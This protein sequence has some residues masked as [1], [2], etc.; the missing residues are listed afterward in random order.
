MNTF[1]L[2]YYLPYIRCCASVITIV[3]FNRLKWN[4]FLPELS[5][6]WVKIWEEQMSYT[7]GRV[8]L[9]CRSLIG[10]FRSLPRGLKG[11]GL[12]KVDY[13]EDRG[14]DGAC[15]LAS[16]SGRHSDGLAVDTLQHPPPPPLS[17]RSP[18]AVVHLPRPT[19]CWQVRMQ[20]QRCSVASPRWLVLLCLTSPDSLIFDSW[21][22]SPAQRLLMRSHWPGPVCNLQLFVVK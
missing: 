6:K 9:P 1:L 2:L 21:R 4:W 19:A 11:S 16:H 7:G 17:P 18:S 12:I 10:R 15:A 3:P 5:W 8:F 13:E 20:R 14:R 22:T